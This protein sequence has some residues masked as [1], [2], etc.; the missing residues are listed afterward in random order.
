M[1][2]RLWEEGADMHMANEWPSL[3]YE[4]WKDTYATLHLF[5]QIVGKVKLALTPWT[6]HAWHAALYLGSRGLTT[7][8]LAYGVRTLEIAFDF[9]DH[10]LRIQAD[11]GASRALPLHPQ[12]VAGFY[13]DMLEMLGQLGFPM[14]INSMPNEIPDAVRFDTDTLHASYD[15]DYV[16]RCWHAMLH[17]HRV[18]T[19][20]RAR[21]LGKC[22]PVHFFWGSFD[23]AVTRF[24]GRRAPPHPAGVPNLPD[25]VARE[26]YSHEVSSVG[27]WPGGAALPEA[28]FYSYAYPEPA[29]FALAPLRPEGAYYHPRMREFVLPYDVVRNAPAPDE[30]LMDFCQS[31]YEAAADGGKWNRAELEFGPDE[32]VSSR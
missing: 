8:P 16:N 32:P 29:G 7:G 31:T 22:S 28:V 17:A 11:E 19:R 5:E 6:N 4:D 1:V 23:L 10:E 21:Y 27:F 15:A 20:F 24:S 9:I 13:R 3:P 25:W 14:R 26:A 30:L 12:P 2:Q 18:F